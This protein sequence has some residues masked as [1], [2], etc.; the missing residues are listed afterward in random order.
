M[1][2]SQQ[3]RPNL[4]AVIDESHNS[5]EVLLPNEC[6]KGPNRWTEQSSITRPSGSKGRANKHKVIF[7]PYSP[8]RA[9]GTPALR[10]GHTPLAPR[11]KRET[12]DTHTK[13]KENTQAPC[14]Y[15]KGEETGTGHMQRSPKPPKVGTK[16]GTARRTEHGSSM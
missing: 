2:T 8:S 12:M 9:H 10:P 6:P 5:K 1:S 4:K 15:L 14:I 7:I 3:L 16:L 11:I 13:P